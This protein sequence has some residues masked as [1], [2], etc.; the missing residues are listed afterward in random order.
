MKSKRSTRRPVVT[1]EVDRLLVFRDKAGRS[2]G[3]VKT[4]SGGDRR[5]A[6][7]QHP[8]TRKR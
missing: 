8:K 2:H 1:T 5:V 3:A 4:S 7:A 6:S